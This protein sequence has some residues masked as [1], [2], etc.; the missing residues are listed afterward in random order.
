MT[1]CKGD[2]DYNLEGG[3]AFPHGDREHGGHPGMTLRDWFAGMALA[4]TSADPNV[5]WEP[6]E[7]ARSKWNGSTHCWVTG[8]RTEQ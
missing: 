6:E 3:P 1:D 7:F 4:G 5:K 2:D 8:H